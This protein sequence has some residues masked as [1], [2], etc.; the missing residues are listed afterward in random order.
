MCR[1]RLSHRHYPCEFFFRVYIDILSEKLEKYF[2]VNSRCMIYGLPMIMRESRIE[3]MKAR[4]AL[5]IMFAVIAVALSLSPLLG[6][7]FCEETFPS[8]ET[9]PAVELR[10]LPSRRLQSFV[11]DTK[12]RVD[13][14]AHKP[15]ARIAFHVQDNGDQY[16][17]DFAENNTSLWRFQCGVAIK[18]AGNSRGILQNKTEH[19]VIVRR[20]RSRISVFVEGKRVCE[21]YDSSFY[22]G[23]IGIGSIDDS[24]RF[25][26]PRIQKTAE[27]YFTDNFM[28]A[29]SEESA[30]EK[31]SG[32]WKL[33]SL[34]NPGLSSNAFTFVGMAKDAA[35]RAIA[36]VGH[37]FWYDY[38]ITASCNPRSEEAFGLCYYYRNKE[39]YGLFSIG[40]KRAELI[41]R[42]DGGTETIGSVQWG[43]EPRQWYELS[44]SVNGDRVSAG[45]D[46]H[47]VLEALDN[48]LIGGK[49]GVHTAG[50]AGTTFDD[51]VVKQILDISDDFSIDRTRLWSSIGGKWAV[52]EGSCVASA[53]APAKYVMGMPT[54]Q[55]YSVSTTVKAPSNGIVGVVARYIDESNYY[56]LSFSSGFS[57]CLLTKVA[58]GNARVLK[59]ISVSTPAGNEQR[60]AL[61]VKGGVLSAFLN[62]SILLE[63]WDDTIRSGQAGL[64]AAPRPGRRSFKLHF[65]RADVKF[66]EPLA[67]LFAVNE[68]F[69]AE[70]TMDNWATTESDW[71]ETAKVASADV[72]SR[73]HRTDFFKNVK[74]KAQFDPPISEDGNVTFFLAADGRD[75]S[76]GYKLVF[77]GGDEI[78]VELLRMGKQVAYATVH[79]SIDE[80]TVLR[81][82]G[83]VVVTHGRRTLLHYD[84]P[85]PLT[86]SRI[87]YAT[88]GDRIEPENIQ[89]YSENV[90]GYTFESA[91]VDWR[92]GAGQWQVTS[93]WSCDPRWSWF[94][95]SSSRLACLWNKHSFSGDQ[96]MEYYVGIKMDLARGGSNYRYRRDINS[97]LAADGEDLNSGYC[98]LFGADG[99]KTTKILREGVEVARPDVPVV[100]DS[101][102][103]QRWYLI[104]A[105]KKGPRVSFYRDGQLVT[106][107]EDAETLEGKQA[108]LWMW[109]VGQTIARVRISAENIE[110]RESPYPQ[111]PPTDH[112]YYSP[113]D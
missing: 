17:V 112:C 77:A 73:W 61:R 14:N 68:I 79:G 98:F 67:P 27:P 80:I 33:L 105:E 45:V 7:W 103:H 34:D 52:E 18:L 32:R 12:L 41:R 65:E 4:Y 90:L 107:Y 104:R 54:W 42:R 94:S 59:E 48:T 51:I 29:E 82:R 110:E 53:K 85:E 60:L 100:I 72:T 16:A 75:T 93:R 78:S 10:L 35:N 76:S 57:K 97:A 20:S 87:G 1:V 25:R 71:T 44:V 31:V 56:L 49:A 13:E 69:A 30:W 63:A 39:D 37:E 113:S 111:R 36:V 50:L 19:G 11:F 6:S 28:R 96:V 40:P 38:S 2:L 47:I 15:L 83:L 108:A 66:V 26:T 88:D 3:L 89:L 21:A 84:D 92:V 64:Y 102:I 5:I 43:F 99:N 95:G 22:G 101:K 106:E 70:K 86:G 55:D 24:V 109:N 23:K 62:D 9:A 46:G 74:I 58:D 8:A 91:P 81:R